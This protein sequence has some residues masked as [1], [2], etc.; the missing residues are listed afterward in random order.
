MAGDGIMR[1]LSVFVRVPCLSVLSTGGAGRDPLP[2]FPFPVDLMASVEPS[3]FETVSL[4]AADGLG[5]RTSD[6]IVVERFADRTANLN[7]VASRC[8][9]FRQACG[10]RESAGRA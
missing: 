2:P 7:I 9:S 8:V 1:H 5:R 6:R 10:P 4:R 3:V